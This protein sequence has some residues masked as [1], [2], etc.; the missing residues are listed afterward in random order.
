MILTV[1][2]NAAVDKTFMI[3][4]FS[5][6]RV[7]RPTQW[8]VTAGGKGVNVA[9]VYAILGGSP[10]A[11]GLLG[12]ANGRLILRSLQEQCIPADFVRVSEEARECIAIIDPQTGAQTEINEAGPTVRPPEVKRFLRKYEQLLDAHNFRWVVLSGSIPPGTPADI[13]RTLISSAKRRGVECVLDS[14][15]QP[16]ALGV[17]A[18]PWMVKP[19]IRELEAWARRN[20]QSTEEVLEAGGSLR[21]KGIEIVAITMGEQGAI[22]MSSDGAWRA[23]APPVAFVSAVGSGDAFVAAFLWSM[24]QGMDVASALSMGVA[25][26]SANAATFGAGFIDRSEVER[27]AALVEV[28]RL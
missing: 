5:V 9:R 21:E 7:H 14:S 18:V 13:Y 24:E 16:L 15:G 25:A 22:A 1:T 17:D 8:R 6:D 27:L 10:F 4:G 12:G 23:I 28:E 3:P 20:L 11:T 19:N 2:L 26:G